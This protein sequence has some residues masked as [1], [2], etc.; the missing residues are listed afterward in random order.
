MTKREMQYTQEQIEAMHQPIPKQSHLLINEIRHTQNIPYTQALKKG[1]ACIWFVPQQFD[2]ETIARLH[3]TYDQLI[4]VFQWEDGLSKLMQSPLRHENHLFSV[5]DQRHFNVSFAFAIQQIEVSHVVLT[6]ESE[7]PLTSLPIANHEVASHVLYRL[8]NDKI[9]PTALMKG[10][11][12]YEP[13]NAFVKCYIDEVCYRTPGISEIRLFSEYVQTKG[14]KIKH[15]QAVYEALETIEAIYN[16]TD[17][18]DMSCYP[19]VNA[20]IRQIRRFLD[21]QDPETVRQIKQDIYEKMPIFHYHLLNEG[22]AETLVIAYCFPPYIDTS[23]NVMAKRIRDKGE[24]VDIISNDMSRI[25]QKDEKLNTLAAHL[26]DTHYLLDAKQAFSSW[27]SIAGFTEQGLEVLAQHPKMYRHLYSRA[28]F[29]QSHFLAFEIKLEQP[30][31]YWRAEF[32]DPLHTT[33]TSDLRYAP[34]QDASYIDSVKQRLHR[35]W[36]PLVDDN[37]FNVCE[38]LA[39]SHA[40]ELIF[41]NEHQLKYMIERFDEKMKQSIQSRAVISRHPI[42]RPH[43]YKKVNTHYPLDPDLIHLGYFGNFYATRG[44]NEI[45]LVCK[46]LEAKGETAFKIHCFTNIRGNI[47]NIY[48]NSDFKDYIVLHPLV[49]YF[50]FLNITQKFD[51]LLLFDAHTTGIKTINPYVPSKLSDYKGSGK[52][53]WA[54]VEEGSTMAQD[55]DIIHTLMADF[56]HYI[57]GFQQIKAAVVRLKRD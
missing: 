7:T 25:R 1:I 27:E 50:E 9:Y 10:L 53:V 16:V 54:F 4:L 26:V 13:I 23:G 30:E 35:E 24:I 40:D 2:L 57:D 12:L 49:G 56:D 45:E 14:V 38:L 41:T 37:V 31:I 19:E 20:L 11:N 8:A 21:T 46:Y 52:K 28:M 39:L 34:I 43:D 15:R 3:R 17:A 42:P 55:N 18:T 51:G 32:S 29:P 6:L 44:F 36:R 47:K 33:V 22:H 5:L 48:R